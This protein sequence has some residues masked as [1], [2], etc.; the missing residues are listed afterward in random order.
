[1]ALI[2]KEK[3]GGGG[4]APIEAGTYPARCCAV[5]DLGIQHVEYMGQKKDQEKILL[6]FELPTERI[7]VDGEEKPRW[8]SCRYTVSLNEKATLRKALDA[9]RGRPFTP[10]ELLGFNLA[11]V[12][13]APCMLTV[14]NKEGANGNTYANIS[15]IS[16]PMKGMAVPELEGEPLVF[17]MES[18]DAEEVFDKLPERVQKVI[19]ESVTWKERKAEFSPLAGVDDDD[20]PPFF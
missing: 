19:E 11:S 17:D 2:A 3:S 6:M 8:L 14:I 13:N 18:D 20:A 12:V 4:F 16:K 5:V 10:E 9:W 1:M 7:E 15:G